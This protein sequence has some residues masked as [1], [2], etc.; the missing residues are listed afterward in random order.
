MD[1]K[2]CHY[3]MQVTDLK[4]HATATLET[5]HVPFKNGIKIYSTTFVSSEMLTEV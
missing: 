1:N 5:A 4:C 3:W 2:E